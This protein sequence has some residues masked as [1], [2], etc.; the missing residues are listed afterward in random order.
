MVKTNYYKDCEEAANTCHDHRSRLAFRRRRTSVE[1][2]MHD[3][4]LKRTMVYL[5]EGAIAFVITE[6]KVV[7]FVERPQMTLAVQSTYNR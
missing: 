5:K 4:T 6:I 3:I 7:I 1:G 2:K